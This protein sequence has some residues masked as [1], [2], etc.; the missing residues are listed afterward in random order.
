M[1]IMS[2]LNVY[3]L[4]FFFVQSFIHSFFFS[5]AFV[6]SL[7]LSHD[8]LQRFLTLCLF[9]DNSMI[10]FGKSLLF[11]HWI[12]CP[13]IILS[14]NYS[15]QFLLTFIFLYF[16]QFRSPSQIPFSFICKYMIGRFLSEIF[17]L[18][19]TFEGDSRS[20][21]YSGAILEDDRKEEGDSLW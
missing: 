5:I 18:I 7:F 10:I 1:L 8:I 13:S 21:T 17:C 12:I 19:I 9:N 2:I 15:L 11:I 6:Y 3:H 16:N 14:F 4:H 20:R